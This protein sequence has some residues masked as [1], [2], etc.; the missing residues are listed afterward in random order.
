MI[1]VGG[2]HPTRH[3]QDHPQ[4]TTH[5]RSTPDYHHTPGRHDAAPC[6][7]TSRRIPPHQKHATSPRV[8][9][10]RA[11]PS[12]H[13]VQQQHQQYRQKQPSACTEQAGSME[14]LIQ[15]CI[16]SHAYASL[17]T[18][19]MHKTSIKHAE[20]KHPQDKHKTCTHAHAHDRAGTTKRM[21]NT[22][23]EHAECLH[24]ARASTRSN[25]SH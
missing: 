17:H 19:H 8:Q 18:K 22:C 11:C 3:A 7:G 6:C 20:A 24:T 21:H 16:Q 4:P 5:P 14:K 9:T 23:I 12:K 25:S 10:T 15:T 2:S 1:P 13:Q